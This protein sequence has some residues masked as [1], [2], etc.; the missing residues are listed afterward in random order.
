MGNMWNRKWTVSTR[1]QITVDDHFCTRYMSPRIK[2]QP[3][4]RD[5]RD[6]LCRG[7][8]PKRIPLE[9]RLHLLSS[10][11]PSHRHMRSISLTVGALSHRKL[12][13]TSVVSNTTPTLIPSRHGSATE[14]IPL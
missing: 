11:Y 7:L 6:E 1:I 14:W 9:I 4:K 3:G 10:L 2:V 12:R 5:G 13:L 8:N